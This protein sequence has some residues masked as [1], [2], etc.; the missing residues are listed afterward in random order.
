[1]IKDPALYLIHIIEAIE[2]IQ[3]YT[4]SGKSAFCSDQMVF[5]AVLRNLQTM[6]EATQRLPQ[7]VKA[8]HPRIAWSKIAGFRN[9]LVHDYLGD[10]DAE[11]VWNVVAKELPAL[12]AAVLTEVPKNGVTGQPD[13]E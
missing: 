8:R 2:K 7:D 13:P 6:S 12:K 11:I 9:I 10:I 5:D 3:R 4:A 1:M